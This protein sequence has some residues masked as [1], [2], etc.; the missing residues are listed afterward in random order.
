MT[1]GVTLHLLVSGTEDYLVSLP[2]G[3]VGPETKLCSSVGR[4]EEYHCGVLRG[5]MGFFRPRQPHRKLS[6]LHL[7]SV[8][9]L[10]DPQ[11]SVVPRYLS[12]LIKGLM[13]TTFIV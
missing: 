12:P 10:S 3:P 1:S 11:R 13:S 5:M 6:G 4:P 7:H 9:G 8:L 2:L